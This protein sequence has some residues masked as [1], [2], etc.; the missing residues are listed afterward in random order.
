MGDLGIDG[1]IILRC[2]GVFKNMVR[3]CVL[4]SSGSG[5]G[6]VVE[7]CEHSHEPSGCIKGVEFL[8]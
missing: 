5:Y 8:D 4:E 1:R 3:G 7:S 2:T 6:P